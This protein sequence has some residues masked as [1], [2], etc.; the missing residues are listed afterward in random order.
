MMF[1]TWVLALGGFSD[2]VSAADFAVPA[3]GSRSAVV[4][5]DLPVPLTAE[6]RGGTTGFELDYDDFGLPLSCTVTASSG[7][8]DLDRATC[9]FVMGARF[10][11]GRD[12]GGHLVGGNYQGRVRWAI[13]AGMDVSE[14]LSALEPP[15]TTD[16]GPRRAVPSAEMAA[17][18]P[19]DHYPDAARAAG[20]QG[21]V[22][23]RLSVDAA[24]GVGDCAV[25]GS[26]GF[27]ALDQAACALMMREGKFL[28]ALDA[29]GLPTA[30]TFTTQYV[31]TL[32]P[33]ETGSRRT[34]DLARLL[35]QARP[36][37][38]TI[39]TRDAANAT[40][41]VL[42]DL[43]RRLNDCDFNGAEPAAMQGIQPCL[44]FSGD[45]RYES[46]VDTS[47]KVVARRILL[48]AEL[49]VE[50]SPIES[51]GMFDRAVS[52]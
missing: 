32:P 28:P 20:E 6:E 52:P 48:K 26:S 14:A 5:S 12:V 50:E 18:D 29:R 17:L 9:R 25:T 35:R 16:H 43:D 42:I 21:L 3:R 44:I 27:E 30:S 2:S 36:P 51:I 41:S 33:E 37:I 8:D 1:F 10:R 4:H 45:T 46:F 24:G 13:P 19:A 34:A 39:P 31:W 49:P 22:Y 23:M 38:R 15:S 11:P 47:G 7:S 40:L